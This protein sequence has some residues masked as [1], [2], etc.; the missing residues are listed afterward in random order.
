MSERTNA[1]KAQRILDA[2]QRL[3][4]ERGHAA[5]TIGEIAREAGVSRGLLHYYFDSKE[6]ILAQVVRRNVETSIAETRRLLATA[7]TREELI[8]QFTR[9]Y[10]H[11]LGDGSRGYAL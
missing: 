3:L 11:A 1:D 2:A 10:R 7:R 4:A 8:T 9:A 5:V 6:H